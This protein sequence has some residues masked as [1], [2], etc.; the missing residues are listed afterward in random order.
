MENLI[1]YLTERTALF[2]LPAVLLAA[3]LFPTSAA[4]DGEFALDTGGRGGGG[5]EGDPLDGN[6]PDDDPNNGDD[7]HDNAGKFDSNNDFLSRLMRS[8]NVLFVPQYNGSI[9][10]FRVIFLA[11]A[12]EV[13]EGRYAR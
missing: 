11:E 7:V 5:L 4:A 2:L 12:R 9:L 1:K 8:T 6:E 10:T 3:G 13:V